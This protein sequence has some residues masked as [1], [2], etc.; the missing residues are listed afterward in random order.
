MGN[1]DFSCNINPLGPPKGL[2]E[3]IDLVKLVSSYPDHT[4]QKAIES[5][6]LY[7]ALP[8]ENLAVGGGS[9]EFFFAIPDALNVDIG[10]VVVPSFWEY[11]ISLKHSNRKLLYFKTYANDEFQINLL[12]LRRLLLTA[13]GR[14]TN[15]TLYLCNPNNPT[16]TLIKPEEILKLCEDFP[17][18]K[19]I[20]DETY[21]LFRQDYDTLSLMRKAS[22]H[23]NL[24]VVTSFSK[25]FTVP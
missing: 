10:I 18:T 6:S 7:Y 8:K 15:P 25:F 5:L 24:I 23:N 20:V 1:I 21:L 11:E 9:T 16:S 14:K 2:L 12:E 17:Q 4:N 22:E 3:K 19:V 13:I